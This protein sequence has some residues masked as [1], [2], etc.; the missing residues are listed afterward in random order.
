MGDHL[1]PKKKDDFDINLDFISNLPAELLQKILGKLPIKEAARNSILSSKWNCSWAEIPDLVFKEDCTPSQLARIVDM[2]LLAHKGP[3]TTFELDGEYASEEAI[4]SWVAILSQNAV[5]NLHLR[6][7]IFEDCKIPPSIFSCHKLEQ[8][9]ISECCIDAP[10]CFEGLKLLRNLSISNCYL[11]GITIEKLVSSCPLLQNL[12]LS[13]IFEHDN[14]VIHGPNL[15]RLNILGRFTHLSLE[16]PKLISA[17][18]FR[19]CIP[20][21]GYQPFGLAN[22]GSKSKILCALGQLSDIENLEIGSMFCAYLA[23]GPI[24]KK[25]PVIFHHLKRIVIH[26]YGR[27]KE[28][29]EV[30]L[31]I[32][33]NA[34]NVRTLYLRVPSQNIWEEQRIRTM[35]LFKHLQEVKILG[36]NDVVSML[37][38][39]KFILSTAPVLEKLV[40]DEDDVS[41]LEDSLAFV[42]KLAS[43]SRLSS[44]AVIVFD[45]KPS[46]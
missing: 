3:I 27:T 35:S 23:S 31:C 20:L 26:L 42:M 7:D 44:K 38:F 14:I 10:E 21:F 46:N 1:H 43:F 8:L 9:D 22:D 19:D 40:I 16:A 12:T 6:F 33:R 39:A 13:Y 28:E 17:S 32:F 5:K 36:F 29:V 30:A 34:P 41:G 24:P 4:N 2:V 15:R 18:I 25:L 45:R 37:G 11:W